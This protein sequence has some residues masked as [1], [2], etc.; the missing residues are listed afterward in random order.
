[1]LTDVAEKGQGGGEKWGAGIGLGFTLEEVD[2]IA[3][4]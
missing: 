3:S 4:V 1:M 2:L